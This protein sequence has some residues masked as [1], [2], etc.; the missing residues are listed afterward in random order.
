MVVVGYFIWL[1]L[2]TLYG[3]TRLLYMVVVV[4]FIWLY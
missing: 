1:H 2:V 3:C 4:C